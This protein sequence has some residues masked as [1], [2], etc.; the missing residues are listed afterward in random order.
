MIRHHLKSKMAMTSVDFI[1]SIFVCSA[2]CTVEQSIC[3]V[4]TERNASV[5]LYMYVGTYVRRCDE[6]GIL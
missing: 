4:K 1:P 6:C 5:T 3:S 2:V